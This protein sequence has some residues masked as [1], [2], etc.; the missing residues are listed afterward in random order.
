[1]NLAVILSITL[2]FGQELTPE[3]IAASA[4]PMD[5]DHLVSQG[6]KAKVMLLVDESGSM[7]NDNLNFQCPIVPYEVDSKQDQLKAALSGCTGEDGVFDLFAGDVEFAIY[8]FGG[9]I[10]LIQDFTADIDTL[11][12]AVRGPQDD[13]CNLSSPGIKACGNT[14]MTRGLNLAASH[15]KSVFDTAFVPPP[16][17]PTLDDLVGLD[18]TVDIGDTDTS[19]VGEDDPR[20]CDRFYVVALG[21]GNPNSG[22]DQTF[23]Q[24]CD[25]TTAN[26]RQ[27]HPG[28]GAAYL[29]EGDNLCEIPGTQNFDT[30][31]IGFGNPNNFNADTLSAMAHGEGFYVEAQDIVDLTNAFGQILESIVSRDVVNFG[32]GSVSNDGLFSGNDAYISSFKPAALDFWPGNLKRAC[33]LP[34][35]FADN[36]YDLTEQECLFVGNPLDGGKSLLTN[37]DAEDQFVQDAPLDNATVGGAAQRIYEDRFGG[38]LVGPN[39][40]IPDPTPAIWKQR[41]LH[42][43]IP[44]EFDYTRVTPFEIDPADLAMAECEAARVMALIHG[45]DPKVPFGDNQTGTFDCSTRLPGAFS[46]W[47]MG[48]VV[49][50]GTALLRYDD[51]CTSGQCLVAVGTNN[52]TIHFVESQSGKE[53]FGLIPGD[54]WQ[55]G[56]IAP[57]PLS[58]I[59][60]QPTLDYRRLP[61]IDG[62]SFLYH[63]DEDQDQVIDS[64]ETALYITGLGHGGAAYYLLDVS[65]PPVPTSNPD[66]A[67][68]GS[69]NPIYSVGRTLTNWTQDMRSTLA[70]PVIGL[71]RFGAT[72]RQTYMAFTSGSDWEAARP[73]HDYSGFSGDFEFP[74]T[75][76]EFVDCATILTDASSNLFCNPP[77]P[78]LAAFDLANP[79]D[80]SLYSYEFG[81]TGSYLGNPQPPYSA[82]YSIVLKL[83][84]EVQAV[85]GARFGFIDLETGDRILIEDTLGNVLVELTSAD[86]TNTPKT[87]DFFTNENGPGGQGV[88]FG[89]RFETDGETQTGNARG[90]QLLGVNVRR[91][92]TLSTSGHRPFLA[93]LEIEALLEPSRAFQ[94]KYVPGPELLLVTRDC[95]GSGVESGRCIDASD[96]PDLQDMVCPIS[97][98]PTPYIE[99]GTTRAFYFGDICG[100]LW[101]VY[102][103]DNGGRWEAIKI[104]E[105]NERLDPSAVA[106][107]TV[108]SR[109]VR[110]IDRPVDIFVTG[111]RGGRSIGVSFGSGNLHRPAAIDDL[112]GAEIATEHY[113]GRDVI[114]TIFDDGFTV[115]SL[116][117]PIRLEEGGPSESRL[118]DTGSGP[119]TVLVANGSCD[120]ACL[121]DVTDTFRADINTSNYRGYF[122][123]L[124]DNER[125]LR[126]PLTVDGITFFKSFRPLTESTSCEAAIGRDTAY[127]V[128]HCTAEPA[129]ANQDRTSTDPMT[130]NAYMDQR[131]AAHNGD[132]GSI[133]GNF[134]VLTPPQGAPIVSA[135]IEGRADLLDQPSAGVQALFWYMPKGI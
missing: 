66:G 104:L 89:I 43:W 30:F 122:F 58:A 55:Q 15:M 68:S 62:G 11:N 44:G 52:A 92:P 36:T 133:G 118:V 127:A 120:G 21:D 72:D 2:A 101:K 51:D 117:N 88:V 38:T 119:Q 59:L 82:L 22:G 115:S 42:T 4:L 5:T 77:D 80:E 39:A 93:V 97:A 45:F 7:D 75:E 32:A 99:G 50:S 65:T 123:A 14:P 13:D 95:S 98:P 60:T 54:L 121:T 109:S 108:E 28:D 53:I 6:G 61:T 33:I 105:L 31:A 134:F 17:E 19:T 135:G 12:N 86:N 27:N 102:T 3:E 116:P 114:G 83:D 91:R 94:S 25:G 41:N 9:T 96:F 49:N 48:A 20:I 34:P 110:R 18:T 74:P 16:P 129:P 132:R 79:T 112:E 63:A 78:R 46:P 23:N 107:G 47:P 1:M 113:P 131:V 85:T 56:A 76:S 69:L 130:G 67:P 37:D 128:T 26:A 57:R 87:I 73:E 29:A 126:D 71:G 40:A 84:P 103:P 124:L 70:A 10:R 8:G 111:C 64:S 90:A 35:R 125:M 106:A 24:R 100:Q 81:F